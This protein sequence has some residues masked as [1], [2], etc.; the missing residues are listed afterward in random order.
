MEKITFIIHQ[1]PNETN[2]FIQPWLVE[3]VFPPTSKF[4]FLKIGVWYRQ[5]LHGPHLSV[6]EDLIHPS[7]NY[8]WQFLKLN[9]YNQI[10]NKNVFLY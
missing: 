4:L 9:Q 6:S 10:H 5:D 2:F 7:K 3:E 1:I 8:F